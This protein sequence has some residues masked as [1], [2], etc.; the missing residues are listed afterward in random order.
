MG[1]R[2]DV[3]VDMWDYTGLFN[4]YDSYD[5]DKGGINTTQFINVLMGITTA[6]ALSYWLSST[7][8]GL[9][10]AVALLLLSTPMVNKWFVLLCVAQLLYRGRSAPPTQRTKRIPKYL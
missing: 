8:P 9:D 5:S 3:T 1:D 4:L 7:I 10:M 6:V 2:Q